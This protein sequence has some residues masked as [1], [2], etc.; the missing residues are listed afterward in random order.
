MTPELSCTH[1]LLSAQM[2]ITQQGKTRMYISHGQSL[3]TEKGADSITI[4]AIG[5]AINKAVTT[6]EILKRR[7]EG[8]HQASAEHRPH[9][10]PM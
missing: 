2:R 9:H 3:L 6:A 8:L 1:V 4:K 7:V 10:L 5:R